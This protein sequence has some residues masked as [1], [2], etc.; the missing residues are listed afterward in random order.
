MLERMIQVQP[1]PE[2]LGLEFASMGSEGQA[3]FFAEVHRVVRSEYAHGLSGFQLNMALAHDDS[4]YSTDG[5]RE[6]MRRIG[7]FSTEK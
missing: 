6:V 2:E 3:R 4:T 5:G 1:S 7:V